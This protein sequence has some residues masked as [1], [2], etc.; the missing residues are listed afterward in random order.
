MGRIP[1]AANRNCGGKPFPPACRQV[2]HTITSHG[3]SR[4]DHPCRIDIG[5]LPPRLEDRHHQGKGAGWLVW[6]FVSGCGPVGFHP[7]GVLRA[8]GGEQV[9][10]ESLPLRFFK[11]FGDEMGKLA[12]IVRSPFS[13]AVE[14]KDQ[15]KGLVFGIPSV[16]NPSVGKPAQCRV[17]KKK[18]FPGFQGEKVTLSMRMRAG[19][20][21]GGR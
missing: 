1:P 18:P 11:K 19:S 14:K 4:Q 6:H 7:L 10:G 13:R 15:G 8:L 20:A 21:P 5:A 9:E 17:D 2:P 12:V 3:N 16:A